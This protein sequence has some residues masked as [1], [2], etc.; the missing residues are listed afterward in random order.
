MAREDVRLL[1]LGLPGLRGLRRRG[2]PLVCTGLSEQQRKVAVLTETTLDVI[3][4]E[5]ELTR[6]WLRNELGCE[7]T[8]LR[9]AGSGARIS[10]RRL[11]Y[12]VRA[13][14]ISTRS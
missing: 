1:T 6:L 5:I 10:E 9:L 7:V 2:L 13:S 8:E 11:R 3:F 12:S 4:R 14:M